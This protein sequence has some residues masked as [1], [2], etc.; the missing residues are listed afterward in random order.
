MPTIEILH[1]ATTKI[2]FY[3]TL[4]YHPEEKFLSIFL[5]VTASWSKRAK[6]NSQLR[7][8]IN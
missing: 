1:S 3:I 6:G 2:K 4:A 8:T 7:P 5:S